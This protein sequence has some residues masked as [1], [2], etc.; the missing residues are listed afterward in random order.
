MGVEDALNEA[1]A[2]IHLPDWHERRR[3]MALRSDLNLMGLAIP[4]PA[5]VTPFRGEAEV[6]GAIYVLEGSRL[7]G[8]VLIR[9]VLD[10][11]S[12][13]PGSL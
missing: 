1:N 7:G 9:T 2:E 10:D 3:T 8:A 6:L 5:Q 12:E 13:R 4:E 11:L